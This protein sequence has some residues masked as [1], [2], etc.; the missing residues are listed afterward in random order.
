MTYLSG[1]NIKA[2]CAEA[3]LMALREHRMRGTNE[4][5]KNSEEHVLYKKQEVTPK[6]IISC[7][8]QLPPRKWLGL[9]CPEKSMFQLIFISRT[10]CLPFCA[11]SV[12]CPLVCLHLLVMY[13]ALF[14]IKYVLSQKQRTKTTTDCSIR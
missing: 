5:F 6:R 1:A 11:W 14:P 13:N 8:P 4:D 7:K 10:S 2:I 12:G 3:R 9:S